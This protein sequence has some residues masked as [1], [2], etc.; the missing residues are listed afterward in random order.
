MILC[1]V[2]VSGDDVFDIRRSPH[3]G[4]FLTMLHRRTLTVTLV[5]VAALIVA[6]GTARGDGPS[7]L[8]HWSYGKPSEEGSPLDEPLEADRPDFTESPKTVGQ[9]VVQL[10]TGYTF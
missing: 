4:S 5:A 6:A 1:G 7:T 9:G 8:M 2:A 10:E 3:A